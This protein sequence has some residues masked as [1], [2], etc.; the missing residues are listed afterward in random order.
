[1]N[2]AMPSKVLR[3]QRHR[4]DFKEVNGIATLLFAENQKSRVL[5]LIH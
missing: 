3:S 2:Q 5:D 1:M 4:E